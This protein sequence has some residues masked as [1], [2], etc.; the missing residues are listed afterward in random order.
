MIYQWREGR[1]RRVMRLYFFGSER[2]RGQASASRRPKPWKA[3]LLLRW[4][5]S[6][7]LAY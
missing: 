2:A 3:S 1:A 5:E 7:P 4:N 6:Q